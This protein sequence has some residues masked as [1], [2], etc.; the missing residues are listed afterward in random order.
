MLGLFGG[1]LEAG[2]SR[3]LE[4]GSIR[5]LRS[6]VECRPQ[7]I[8]QQI[9]INASVQKAL[10]LIDLVKYLAGTLDDYLEGLREEEFT[11]I[12]GEFATD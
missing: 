5:P 11:I 1:R 10:E 8:F 6:A 2:D 4:S 9:D 3:F 12:R 7:L